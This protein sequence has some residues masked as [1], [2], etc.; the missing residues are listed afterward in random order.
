MNGEN[1]D[2][3]ENPYGDYNWY[4]VE[5]IETA[6]K[7]VRVMAKNAESAAGYL[8]RVVSLDNI[9][10]NKDI[11]KYTKELGAVF[12]CDP[13]DTDFMVPEWWYEDDV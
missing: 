11:D 9:D 1:M 12:E 7:V 6:V 2:E 8:E 10:T 4:E 13:V 5:V 3:Y